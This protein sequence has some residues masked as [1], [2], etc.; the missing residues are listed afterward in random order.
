MWLDT[1]IMD[2]GTTVPKL[3]LAAFFDHLLPPLSPPILAN[4]DNICRELAEPAYEGDTAAF[5]ND[6]WSSLKSLKDSAKSGKFFGALVGIAEAVQSTVT[7]AIPGHP[8]PYLQFINGTESTPKSGFGSVQTH[9]GGCFI[10]RERD[11]PSSPHW[12]DVAATGE[13]KGTQLTGVCHILFIPFYLT[14]WVLPSDSI[15]RR[16]CGVC[17][18]LSVTIPGAGLR[19]LSRSKTERCASGMPIAQRSMFHSLST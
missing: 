16:C 9:P 14:E 15:L 17:I 3:S 6:S 8:A 19:M 1:I 2:A 18:T 10:R 13:Y 12:M 4:F 5:V 11:S 7:K